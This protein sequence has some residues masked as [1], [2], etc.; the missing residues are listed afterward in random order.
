MQDMTLKVIYRHLPCM[1]FAG[2]SEYQGLQF[3]STLQYRNVNTSLE[4]AQVN[5]VELFIF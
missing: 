4:R 1:T 5:S 3:Y 2:I